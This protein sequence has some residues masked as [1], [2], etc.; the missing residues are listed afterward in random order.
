MVVVVTCRHMEG[1]VMEMGVVG[2]CRRK[3]EVGD[4]EGGNPDVAVAASA[5]APNHRNHTTKSRTSHHCATHRPAFLSSN[6][7]ST[8]ATPLPAPLLSISKLHRQPNHFPVRDCYDG[9]RIK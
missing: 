6:D 8:L 7:L 1:E 9:G 4:G 3:E 5:L 2:T